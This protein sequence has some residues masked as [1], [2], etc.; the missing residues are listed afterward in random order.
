MEVYM[1]DMVIK[2]KT[3]SNFLQDVQ[4]TFESEESEHETQPQEV[5]LR[6]RRKEIPWILFI[7]WDIKTDQMKVQALVNMTSPKTVKEV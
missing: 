5:H 1:D 2:S 7:G 3:F 6:S 4:E